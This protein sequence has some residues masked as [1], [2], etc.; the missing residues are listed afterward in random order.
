MLY[1]NVFDKVTKGSITVKFE[2][3]NGI[4]IMYTDIGKEVYDDKMGVNI[5]PTLFCS[6]R[7]LPF[8]LSSSKIKKLR[9]QPM[10]TN[11]KFYIK[12]LKLKTPFKKIILNGVQLEKILNKCCHNAKK[13][14]HERD[15]YVIYPQNNKFFIEID[16]IGQIIKNNP[17]DYCLMITIICI[18]LII[19]GLI[20]KLVNSIVKTNIDVCKLI[21]I[22]NFIL[23]LYIPSLVNF[24]G[25]KIG[26]NTEKRNITIAEENINL[27]IIENRIKAFETYYNDSFG[28]RNILIYMNAKINKELFNVSSVEK[29]LIGKDNW[30]YYAKED[31]KDLTRQYRG[32]DKFTKQELFRIK[33]NLENRKNWLAKKGM[34]FILV[35]APNKESIYPQYYDNVKYR[36]VSCKTRLDQLLEYLN[37]HSN[38]DILDL[39]KTLISKTNETNLYWKTDTHWNEYGAYYGYKE[40]MD[41]VSKK[42]KVEK[43][44]GLDK[45]NIINK[46]KVPSGGDLANML[47]LPDQYGEKEIKL[48]PKTIRTSIQLPRENY[49]IVNGKV[50]INP[51]KH[52]HKMIMLGDSFTDSLIPFMSEHFSESI[53][54]KSYS[55]NSELIK[56]VKPDIVIQEVVERNL[57][58]LLLGNPISV[59]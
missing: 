31:G 46:Y 13:I 29:V 36:K 42:I 14:E 44:I 53:Y 51:K 26:S 52:L 40:I 6:Y 15:G 41:E 19:S 2:G 4:G 25:I 12:E 18:N 45:F 9:I 57:E 43:P 16:N 39:R 21:F 27:G 34:P 49:G 58:K 55:F 32:I 59:R 1:R 37:E 23:I 7:E 28:L 22:I 8:K 56:Y 20:L 48:S 47:S 10:N 11:Y 30:L 17:R 50:M 38:I 54:E 33:T 3:I 35:I 24:I 5:G